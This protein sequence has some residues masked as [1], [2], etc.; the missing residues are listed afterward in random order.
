MSCQEGFGPAWVK[1]K[2]PQIAQEICEGMEYIHSFQVLHRD[3]TPGNVFI[4]ENHVRVADFGLSEALPRV[5][6]ATAGAPQQFAS[7]AEAMGTMLYRA[8]ESLPRVL[9]TDGPAVC[10][11]ASDVYSFGLICW[12]M[13]TRETPWVAHEC[14]RREGYC[15]DERPDLLASAALGRASPCL[16]L[17]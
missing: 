9:E 1:S 15:L 2:L 4:K 5:A 6:G 3:L 13:M 10:R 11:A 8:P 17:L 7:C 14:L 12:H 16:L